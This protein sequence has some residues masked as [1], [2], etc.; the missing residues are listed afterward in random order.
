M[1]RLAPELIS[2]D[3]EVD[4]T[5][6]RGWQT[7]YYSSRQTCVRPV[8]DN[9]G[10]FSLVWAL[11]ACASSIPQSFHVVGFFRF[12]QTLPHFTGFIYHGSV[13]N[14][15]KGSTWRLF[16]RTWSN[17]GFKYVTRRSLD[18]R[19]EGGS[20]R[21]WGSSSSVTCFFPPADGAIASVSWAPEVPDAAWN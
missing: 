1:Q 8:P 19:N 16:F 14:Y 5:V 6:F 10:S 12:P 11:C 3:K 15:K 21:G 17:Y 4:Q 7:C 13:T 20:E 9:A 18:R 2:N